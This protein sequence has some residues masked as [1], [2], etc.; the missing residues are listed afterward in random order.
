MMT[1]FAEFTHLRIDG[2]LVRVLPHA[3]RGLTAHFLARVVPQGN[4][5]SDG[6][7]SLGQSDLLPLLNGLKDLT[8]APSQV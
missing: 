4:D 5:S 3:E 7:A 1:P 2:R 6:L 8:R